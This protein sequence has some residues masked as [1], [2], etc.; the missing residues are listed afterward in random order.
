MPAEKKIAVGDRTVSVRMMDDSY[1]V[2][3]CPQ[4]P[5][6]VETLR[7]RNGRH[8]ACMG[9]FSSRTPCVREVIED[10]RERHGNCAAIAWDGDTIVGILTFFPVEDLIERQARGIEEMV[11][12]RDSKTLALGSWVLCSLE[13]GEF[14]GKGIGR[15]MAEMMIEWAQESGFERIGAFYVPSGLATIHWRD[16]CRPPKP[17]WEKLGFSVVSK[18]L[19]ESTWEDSRQDMENKMARAK[20]TGEDLWMLERFPEYMREFKSSGLDYAEFGAQYSLI[21]EL[22]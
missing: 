4:R 15:A 17:F 8:C 3:D 10:A 20:E 22:D 5:E 1:I 21:Q 13:G 14:R 11:P 18:R 2:S 6:H 19:G 16:N 9:V 12:Y 7:Q